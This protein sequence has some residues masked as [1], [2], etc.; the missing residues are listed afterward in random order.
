MGFPR[1]SRTAVAGPLSISYPRDWRQVAGHSSAVG[2]LLTSR[3]TLEPADGDGALVA[4]IAGPT[5]DSPSLP[6]DV[7]SALT[8]VRGVTVKLGQRS[9]QRYLNLAAPWGVPETL[10]ALPTTAGTVIVDCVGAT[11]DAPAFAANCERSVASLRLR[12]RSIRPVSANPEFAKGLSAIVSKLNTA[13]SAAGR[14]LRTADRSPEQ[15]AVAE[16]LAGAYNDAARADSAL[17]PVPVGADANRDIVKAFHSLGSA[18]TSLAAAA[19]HDDK[20]GYDAGR[21][22]VASA[23]QDLTAGLAELRLEGYPPS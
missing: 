12:L 10:Y 5:A 23:E 2:S 3:I 9:Y 15:A 19:S 21:N 22:A 4:G 13:T 7:A 6:A 1:L 18:Y 16:R 20:R 17:N 8:S 11:R 14:Q